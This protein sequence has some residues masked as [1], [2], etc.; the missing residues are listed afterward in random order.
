MKTQEVKLQSL[1]VKRNV[2]E[3]IIHC[4]ATPAGREVS[5]AEIDR[6]HRERGFNSIGY[7]YVIHADGTVEA[8]RP[9]S[10]AGAHCRGHNARS[11]GVVYV[12]GVNARGKP[13]DTRTAAQRESLLVLVR[14]LKERYPGAMIHGHCEFAAKACPC[15]NAAQEY[16]GL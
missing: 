12:G 16:A 6:W 1:K 9:E 2:N 11:V 5:V 14:K 13:E 3:I 10:V 15:F 4:T 7:H 8:G